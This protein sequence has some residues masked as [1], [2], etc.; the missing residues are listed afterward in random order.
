MQWLNH[1]QPPQ[2]L[3]FSTRMAVW[4]WLSVCCLSTYARCSAIFPVTNL[5]PTPVM[6]I[7]FQL[8]VNCCVYRWIRVNDCINASISSSPAHRGR[9]LG[10]HL[11]EIPPVCIFQCWTFISLLTAIFRSTV[12]GFSPFSFRD[13]I[14]QWSLQ[15]RFIISY[16]RLL[17]SACVSVL[18]V[19]NINVKP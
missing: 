7:I 19:S 18:S 6:M 1:C 3:R 9:L 13:Y 10:Q 11:T 8:N 17:P 5:L 12:I 16:V 15:K 14:L 2:L 4:W